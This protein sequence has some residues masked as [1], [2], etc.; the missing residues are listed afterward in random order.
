MLE[1]ELVEELAEPG[2]GGLG[3]VLRAGLVLVLAGEIVHAIT[4]QTPPAAAVVAR[5]S[6]ASAGPMS[7]SGS[8]KSTQPVA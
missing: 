8:L 4:H 5:T 3:A 7:S 2:V 1:V 6:R